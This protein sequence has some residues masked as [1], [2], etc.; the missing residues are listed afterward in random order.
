MKTVFSILILPILFT[1]TAFSQCWQSISGGGYFNQIIK[2]DQSVWAWGANSNGQLGDG[3]KSRTNLA[4]LISNE[5]NWSTISTGRSHTLALKTNGSLWAW[6]SNAGGELGDGTKQG[7]TSPVQIGS[8]FDGKS[9]DAALGFSLAIK[10]NGTLW[11]WGFNNY[12][13][14]GDGTTFDNPIPT[15]IGNDTNWE[16]I[17]SSEGLHA[18]GIKNDG[19]LWSWG[20][21]IDGQ[22]GIGS[23]EQK[24]I[25]TQV[26]IDTNWK[27]VAA[28]GY[29]T[30]AIKTDG[31]L[32]AWGF[33][34]SGELGDGTFS[35]RAFPTRIGS[36]S[37]WAIISAGFS[38]SVGIKN[39]GSL[40]A[41][42]YNH[43]GQAGLGNGSPTRISVPTR[44]GT[45]SD[46]QVVSSGIYHNIAL[47][48]DGTIWVW[49][50]NSE[51]QIGD[52][53][54]NL[55]QKEPKQ[56]IVADCFSTTTNDPVFINNQI[57]IYP[58][59]VTKKLYISYLNS[60]LIQFED[61]EILNSIGNRSKRFIKD[62][63][64]EVGTLPA[65]IYTIKLT[66][67][68]NQIAFK[69]FIKID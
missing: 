38:H 29:H 35:S 69:K 36:D 59:P 58:N 39:D 17:S 31:S 2:K 54:N 32:W 23:F 57:S 44:V 67:N 19:T 40:W 52:G 27:S 1:T 5:L 56:L 25:P 33:N 62:N 45:E 64:I 66:N 65:G 61:A 41:W 10:S 12:G 18:M 3:T 47:K 49:G 14:L 55:D 13:Q 20:L 60:E 50:E 30:I 43:R 48:K 63:Q 15:Q 24:L 8:D 16:K 22:L 4:K 11:A 21:N 42:G 6:G 9:I 28:G 7:K 53:S 34:N 51:G 37:D 46:W 26:G 68:V